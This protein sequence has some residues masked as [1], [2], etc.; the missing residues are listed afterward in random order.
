MG[1]GIGIEEKFGGFIEFGLIYFVC[2]LEIALK[3]RDLLVF[4]PKLILFPD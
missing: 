4:L 1:V 3:L 2:K